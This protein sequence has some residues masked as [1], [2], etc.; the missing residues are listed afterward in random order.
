MRLILCRKTT[1]AG[2]S[3]PTKPDT[4]K[5][6][7]NH[8][9]LPSTPTTPSAPSTATDEYVNP[10]TWNEDYAHKWV[11]I[12]NITTTPT[13][14][15]NPIANSATSAIPPA[16]PVPPAPILPPNSITTPSSQISP[17]T[18]PT[19]SVTTSPDR[20]PTPIFPV[21][22]ITAKHVPPVTVPSAPISVTHLSN[23]PS[24][25]KVPPP[26]PF[27]PS[28]KTS[29]DETHPNRP[30]APP[31]SIPPVASNSAFAAKGMFFLV[32]SLFSNGAC[33]TGSQNRGLED[34]AAVC[35]KTTDH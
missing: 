10:I 14:P 21:P 34:V 30:S 9:S 20:H 32:F 1:D 11:K 19:T 22:S 8:K 17:P 12:P 2:K 31:N 5:P 6:D 18:I 27:Q 24:P 35:A 23:F 29:P 16:T 33:S 3:E 7:N 13:A 26:F 25:P 15:T 28:I 4:A